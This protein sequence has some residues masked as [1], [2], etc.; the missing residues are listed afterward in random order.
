MDKLEGLDSDRVDAYIH[1]GVEAYV[2]KYVTVEK[3]AAKIRQE[4]RRQRRL[5][6]LQL[7]SCGLYKKLDKGGEVDR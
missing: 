5:H 7:L 2:G 1:R 6:I 3:L 4:Y